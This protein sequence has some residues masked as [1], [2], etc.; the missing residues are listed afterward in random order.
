ML[1]KHTAAIQGAISQSR[2]LGGSVGLAIAT[3]IQN[4]NF[5]DD[6][7]NIIDPQQLAGLQ[8]SLNTL[9]Q[10]EKSKQRQ[11]R[12]VFAEAFNKE[13]RVCMYVSTAA[14]VLSFLT[15]S[16]HATSV[17]E[18][19]KNQQEMGLRQEEQQDAVESESQ[20]MPL[21]RP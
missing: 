16:R 3:V 14:F 2:M 12:H 11:V 6:L 9:D 7:K 4:G 13:M 18:H 19:R 8:K 17:T 15:L 21:S 5:V 1:T 10:L 20:M